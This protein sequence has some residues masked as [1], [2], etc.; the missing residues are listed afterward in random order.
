[1]PA[2]GTDGASRPAPGQ[3]LARTTPGFAGTPSV[4]SSGAGACS[5][6]FLVDRI[7]SVGRS[8]VGSSAGSA[9]TASA[10]QN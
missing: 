8:V 7:A 9:A 1:M 4:E 6:G 3:I 5:T 10:A 2:P